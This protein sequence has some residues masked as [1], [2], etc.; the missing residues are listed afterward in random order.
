MSFRSILEEHGVP[1]NEI[2][3]AV[4]NLRK[5]CLKGFPIAL[6]G[7]LAP[8]VVGFVLLFRFVKREDNEMPKW[9]RWFDNNV[10]MNGDG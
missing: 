4:K 2:D 9:C 6:I 7:F 3:A 5:G 1:S 10:S 8:I